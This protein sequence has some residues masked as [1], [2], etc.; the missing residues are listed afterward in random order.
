MSRA[1]LCPAWEAT[2]TASGEAGGSPA[3]WRASSSTPPSPYTVSVNFPGGNGFTAVTATMAQSVSAAES[4]TWLNYTPA[5]SSGG[6]FTITAYVSG[7]SAWAQPPTGTVTF[8][9]SDSSGQTIL[10]QGGDAVPL[11]AG[12]ATCSL[13]SA[14]TQAALPLTVTATYGGDG[15]YES[16][17]SQ[18]GTINAP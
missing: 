9:V 4:Q 8:L 18:I 5:S 17:M 16:S 2:T 6:A 15:N 10:C 11:S 3:W 14:S 12:A 1:R 13:G 7:Q